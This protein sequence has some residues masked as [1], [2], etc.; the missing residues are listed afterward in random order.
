M[1]IPSFTDSAR[2]RAAIAKD[3]TVNWRRLFWEPAQPARTKKELDRR[4]RLWFWWGSTGWQA[5]L[6]ARGVTISAE[7]SFARGR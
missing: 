3:Q 1:S 5:E 6:A 2:L 7:R 4:E